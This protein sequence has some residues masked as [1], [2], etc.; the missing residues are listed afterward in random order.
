MRKCSKQQQQ[1]QDQPAVDIIDFVKSDWMHELNK[2]LTLLANYQQEKSSI[3]DYIIWKMTKRAHAHDFLKYAK[4]SIQ[5][6]SYWDENGV[7]KLRIRSMIILFEKL[8][9]KSI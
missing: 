1:I 7:I 3:Y 9:R 6:E 2:E 5:T 8:Q 4:D